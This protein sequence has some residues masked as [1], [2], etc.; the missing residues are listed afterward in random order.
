MILPLNN[1]ILFANLNLT[2][3]LTFIYITNI[4]LHD[5]NQ[6][7]YDLFSYG[8]I[9]LWIWAEYKTRFVVLLLFSFLIRGLGLYYEYE[10]H[11]PLNFVCFPDFFRELSL[12]FALSKD[13]F[14]DPIEENIGVH[15]VLIV[16]LKAIYESYHHPI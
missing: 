10:H 13:G 7:Q 8:V 15:L 2:T 6:K 14:I 1:L 12:M 11:D 16:A 5:S 4:I 3:K 9:L